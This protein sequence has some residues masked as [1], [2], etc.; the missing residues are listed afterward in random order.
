MEHGRQQAA[1]RT[2]NVRRQKNGVRQLN[3]EQKNGVRQLNC[4]QKNGV[5]QLNCGQKDGVRLSPAELRTEKRG[6]PAE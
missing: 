5:R 3:C 2:P 1:N 6:M 4:G